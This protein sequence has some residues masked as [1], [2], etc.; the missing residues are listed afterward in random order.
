MKALISRWLAL[1]S[2]AKEYFLYS[3]KTPNLIMPFYYRKIVRGKVT[4]AHIF[5]TGYHKSDFSCHLG[6]KNSTFKMNEVNV[7][8]NIVTPLSF[9]DIIP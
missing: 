4:N 9:K 3:K 8:K 5:V 2:V 7:L 1:R 6:K